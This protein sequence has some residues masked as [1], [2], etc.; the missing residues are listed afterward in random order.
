[1][2]KIFTTGDVAKLCHVT[3]NTVV[4]WSRLGELNGFKIPGSGARRYVRDEVIDFMKKHGFPVDEALA[5][6]TTVL[7]VDDEPEVRNLIKKALSEE[8]DFEII[9]AVSGFEAGFIANKI[10][11]DIILLDIKLGDVDGREVCKLLKKDANLYKTKVIAISG[12][13]S[14]QE[15]MKLRNLGF[16]DYVK[17]PFRIAKLR[18]R[19]LKYVR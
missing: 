3:I 9:E 18:S 12:A 7:V 16:V 14:T 19:I 15:A 10:R 2:K 17:K 8:S 1:M 11:P 13:I 6:K 5:A 4:K